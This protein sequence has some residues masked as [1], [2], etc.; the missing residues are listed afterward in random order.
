MS[1]AFSAVALALIAGHAMA[2]R[3]TA[4]EAAPPP[5]YP[6]CRSCRPAPASSARRSAIRKRGARTV[7]AAIVTLAPAAARSCTSTACRCF[8]YIL[9]GELTVVDV[10]PSTASAPTSRGGDASWSHERPPCSASTPARAVRLLAST[11]AQNT[12]GCHPGRSQGKRVWKAR[13]RGPR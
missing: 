2:G 10:R 13:G 5:D 3:A 4:Q 11:R 6:R 12:P 8:A 1:T 7:T 9:D